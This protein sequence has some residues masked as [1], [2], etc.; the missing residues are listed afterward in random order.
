[1][2]QQSN[3]FGNLSQEGLEAAR[4]VLGGGGV[5]ESDVYDGKIVMA[6]AG[7]SDG[8]AN[9]LDIKIQVNDGRFYSE[10]VYVTNKQGEN[11]YTKD[12][13][14]I[15]LPGFTTANDLALMST[16]FDLAGQDFEEKVV[17]IYNFD[18][19]TEVPTK[20]QVAV[21]MLGKPITIAVL[22][23]I[24][25]K[26]K[27]NDANGQYEP[28]GEFRD[29]NTIDKVFHNES[30]KTVSEFVG[31]KDATFQAA[32]RDKN[33]GKVRDRSKGLAGKTGAPG[34]TGAPSAASN[35]KGKSLFGG[36]G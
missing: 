1:M 15:P 11:Y 33:K 23:Q 30:G 19:K 32:W 17:P 13:K 2:N 3:P 21:G 27:K 20:V 28:T 25:D 5:L 7:K 12:G 18:S 31:K 36:T 26:T 35:G 4:D 10:R 29:T 24:E 14:K 6:Y 16:G 9:F 22:K 8:G 34:R